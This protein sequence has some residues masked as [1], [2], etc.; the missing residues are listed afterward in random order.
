MGSLLWGE[1][2]H[3][4]NSAAPSAVG[5]STRSHGCW[6]SLFLPLSLWPSGGCSLPT[7]LPC[8]R[9]CMSCPLAPPDF[10]RGFDALVFPACTMSDRNM[11]L[12]FSEEAVFGRHQA[13]LEGAV[14]QWP[15]LVGRRASARVRPCTEGWDRPY[16][17]T[18]VIRGGT[19]PAVAE[20][21]FEPRGKV[22][23]WH[24]RTAGLSLR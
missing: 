7:C 19:P 20:T 10:R 11:L 1:C 22:A 24:A 8:L 6:L 17:G 21:A 14:W 16:A 23:K 5:S 3:R 15:Q 2:A 4:C 9:S 12:A 13:S 18:R